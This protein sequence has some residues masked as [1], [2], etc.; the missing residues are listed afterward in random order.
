MHSDSQ[1]VD[2]TSAGQI[3]PARGQYGMIATAALVV[4]CG[5]LIVCGYGVLA[6]YAATPGNPSMPPA[7]WPAQ[8][9][10]PRSGTLPTLIMLAHPKCPCTRASIGELAA[11]MRHCVGRVDAC[12]AFFRPGNATD[13]WAQSDLWHSAAAIPGIKVV[14]DVDGREARR[15]GAETSGTVVLY[16]PAGRLL[17]S[18]GITHSRGMAGESDGRNTLISLITGESAVLNATPVYGCQ[19]L[20]S[21]DPAETCT[22]GNEEKPCNH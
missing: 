15:F 19:L 9:A 11:V 14:S 4:V 2:A 3:K 10:I 13:G 18:G 17:F 5:A 12:V 6:R 16:D 21:T 1:H 22:P 8:S 20:D 7:Q